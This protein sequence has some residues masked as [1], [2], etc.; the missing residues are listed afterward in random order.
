VTGRVRAIL[1]FVALA[2]LHTWPLASAPHRLSLNHNADT[3]LNTWIVSW[4]AHTLPTHPGAFW[5]GN[6]FQPGEDALMFSE[7][8]V[9]PAIVG[10]PVLWLGGSPVLMFNLLLIAGLAA[11]GFA[12]W[13]VVTRW[14]GSPPAGLVA[15]A[16]FAFNPHLL[17]RLP[18]LQAVHVWGLILA[19]Y[20]AD[21]ALRGRGPWWPL[22]IIWPLVAATSLHVL[23]FASGAVVLLAITT[24]AETRRVAG[25]T[26][27]AAATAAGALLAMPVLW[28]H[29]ARGI[30]RPLVQVADFSATPGGYLTSMSHVHQGWTARFFT[31]D[32]DVFFPGFVAIGLAALG[33]VVATQ[34][35]APTPVRSRAVWLVLI[36]AA[37]VLLSLGTA[38]PIYGWLYQWLPPLQGIRAAARFGIWYLMAIA[39]LSGMAVAWFERRVRPAAVPWIVTLIVAGITIENV[40]API[41]T[42]PFQGVPP[43]YDELAREPDGGLLVEFPFYPPD[44]IFQNGEYVLNATAHWRPIANGYSGFTPMSYRERSNTLWFFPDQVAVDTL[45]ALGATHAMVHLER[46]LD[47]APSVI[48][49]LDTQPRLRLVAADAQGHRLYRVVRE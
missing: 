27:L 19:C 46:F 11:S 16:L 3:Q 24:M 9:V 5:R 25:L 30:K 43:I 37:G 36:A 48:R 12:A 34:R 18:H 15:G 17:T 21:Q 28:P 49:A 32:I 39:V 45:L 14:T 20:F 38:T 33:L 47:Q 41:H 22:V 23:L 8:L 40:M 29:V 2:V 4:I 1:I 6:I 13:R 7:P 42:T 44:G 35:K 10:S 31:T 26:R